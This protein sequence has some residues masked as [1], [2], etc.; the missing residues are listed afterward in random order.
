LSAGGQDEHP[1]DVKSSTTT[2]ESAN[3]G[4]VSAINAANIVASECFISV[5]NPIG[6][7]LTTVR[8]IFGETP[9]K[10]S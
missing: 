1:W 5:S 4:A 8:F 2:G 9:I 6:G 3:A 10:V 7:G